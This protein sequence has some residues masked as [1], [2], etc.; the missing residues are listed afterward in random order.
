VDDYL[1]VPI[2]TRLLSLVAPKTDSSLLIKRRDPSQSALESCGLHFSRGHEIWKSVI[3]VEAGLDESSD[4]RVERIR[5]FYF[6]CLQSPILHSESI[7]Q[8]YAQWEK[9][10]GS[11]ST[12]PPPQVQS[13]M[14]STEAAVEARK[15]Y[16]EALSTEDPTDLLAAYVA[17]CTMEERHGSLQQ[18]ECIYERLS[19]HL[20]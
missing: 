7:L 4:D 20:R 11:M 15:K 10:R 9:A 18:I 1:S 5:Q 12:D 14:K 16:E 19:Q 2:W 17:Y 13:M 6:E 3:D 8:S